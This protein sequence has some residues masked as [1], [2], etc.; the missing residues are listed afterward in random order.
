VVLVGGKEPARR[1]LDA[2]VDESG[3]L[4]GLQSDL[5]SA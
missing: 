1:G 4:S 3:S 2:L 5:G